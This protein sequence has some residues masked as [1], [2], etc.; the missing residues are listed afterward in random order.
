MT[1]SGEAALKRLVDVALSPVGGGAQAL[2]G[3]L[4]RKAA[5]AVPRLRNA[6]T[7][8]APAERI[9]AASA[10]WFLGTV[11]KAA[12]PALEAL[13]K[14]DATVAEDLR[15]AARRALERIRRP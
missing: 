1:R 4:G 13:L 10:L 8:G 5:P 6:L 11:A 14:E 7:G 2:L 3:R 12:V 15:A 9:Q